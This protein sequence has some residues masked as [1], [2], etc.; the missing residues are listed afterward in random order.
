MSPRS[1][2]EKP[3]TIADETSY[4]NPV[5]HDIID[6]DGGHKRSDERPKTV[7][8]SMHSGKAVQV[9]LQTDPN[10]E[11]KVDQSYIKDVDWVRMHRTRLLLLLLLLLFIKAS[12]AEE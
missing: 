11:T 8:R 7:V 12:V 1:Y 3:H 6:G 10:L 5:K 9:N 2:Q 4:E